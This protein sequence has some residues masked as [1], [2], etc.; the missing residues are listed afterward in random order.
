MTSPD[1]SRPNLKVIRPVRL[2]INSLPDGSN[3][4]SLENPFTGEAASV[5]EEIK[6]GKKSKGLKKVTGGEVLS[7]SYLT[8]IKGDK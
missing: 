3:C 1:Y 8:V 5:N 7:V 2:T 4:F 6:F